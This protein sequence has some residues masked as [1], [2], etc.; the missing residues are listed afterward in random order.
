[1]T[2]V[3]YSEQPL[4]CFADRLKVLIGNASVSAFARKVGLNESLIRKYLNG[5]EPTLSR[6]AKIAQKTA[7]NVDWLAFGQGSPAQPK[8][9]D[10]VALLQLIEQLSQLYS[11]QQ[12]GISQSQR[13]LVAVLTYQHINAQ[14]CDITECDLVSAYDFVVK[15]VQQAAIE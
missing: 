1:M 10:A 15:R 12:G 6:A 4:R 13:D 7:V 14:C 8:L 3:Q 2:R 5:S 11:N 9:T